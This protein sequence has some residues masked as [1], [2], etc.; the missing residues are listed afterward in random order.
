[1]LYLGLYFVTY[2][3]IN[4]IRLY[5]KG[6]FIGFTRSRQNQDPNNALVTIEGVKTR[7]DTAFY[8]GKRVAYVYR[9]LR[10]KTRF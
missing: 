2:K 6:A 9:A 3:I 8:L 10:K 1:M 7:E 4:V 5:S